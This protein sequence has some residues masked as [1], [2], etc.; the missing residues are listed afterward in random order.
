MVPDAPGMS[1]ARRIGL[2]AVLALTM[3]TGTFPGYAVGV[4]GPDLVAEFGLTAA[5]LGLVTTGIYAVGGFGSLTAGRV[6]DRIGPRRTMVGAFAIVAA[7]LVWMSR[8]GSVVWLVI[9]AAASGASLA[10]GNPAT[11]AAVAENVPDGRRGLIMGTKQ[12]GVQIGAFLAGSL[13]APAAA[14][15][16]WREALLLGALV[17]AAGVPLALLLVPAD[18]PRH[19]RARA[20]GPL[21]TA[22]RDLAVYAFLM[23]AVVG[24]VMTHLPLYAVARLDVT[25][26]RAG[27]IAATIGLVGVVSR[28]AWGWGSERLASHRGPLALMGFGAALAVTGMLGAG[29][30]GLWA[31]WAG[32][33]LFGATA[34]T[35]NSVGMLAVVS[36]I[37]TASPGRATG[38]VLLGYYT[39]FVPGPV[40]FG[41]IVDLTGGYALAWTSLAVTLVFAGAWALRDADAPARVATASA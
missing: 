11:N 9:A 25:T 7:S 22:V 24:A 13:L 1:L 20:S 19:L 8:S 6:V 16:G 39:G 17:P 28:I 27:A 2:T 37:G 15:L 41:A 4:L 26:T 30:V 36:R 21:P 29:R 34:V 38:L 35:W 32:A 5:G 31:A 23:G 10:A 14:A 33:V 40:I 12:S 18:A 3:G